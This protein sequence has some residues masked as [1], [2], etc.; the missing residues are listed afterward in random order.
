MARP[1]TLAG[2]GGQSV[3]VV[4]AAVAEEGMV[5][6]PL[7][8][9]VIVLATFVPPDNVLAPPKACCTRM[10]VP[11]ASRTIQP[12]AQVP[13]QPVPLLLAQTV[14]LAAR[15][16]ASLR[17]KLNAVIRSFA[18]VAIRL[19]ITNVW[20]FGTAMVSRI[21]A[22]ASVT[23]NSIRVNPRFEAGASTMVF[24]FSHFTLSR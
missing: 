10:G 2:L 3:S 5:V 12:C 19:L 13:V 9:K 17:A 23:S 20:K 14:T 24:K 11:A 6:R 1:L 21:A 18:C 8:V 15:L 16:T 22:T 7:E 4:V